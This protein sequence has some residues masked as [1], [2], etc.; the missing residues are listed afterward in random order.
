MSVNICLL[1]KDTIRFICRVLV[2]VY[3]LVC[4]VYA[5]SHCTGDIDCLSKLR[6]KSILKSSGQS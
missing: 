1:C 6:F 4:F 3:G 5:A 2:F